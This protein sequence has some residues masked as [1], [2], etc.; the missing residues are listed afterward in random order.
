MVHITPTGWFRGGFKLK[1]SSLDAMSGRQRAFTL[2]EVLLVMAI[3]SILGAIAWPG[4][5]HYIDQ[6]RVAQAKVD[7]RAIEGDL[8]NYYVNNN[9]YPDTLAAAG[10][11]DRRDPWGN[12]YRYLR[13]TPT[14]SKGLLRK[15]RNLVPIN[16]DYDLYSLGKDGTSKPPLTAQPS[17]DDVIRAN[18]GRFVGLASDY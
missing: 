14:T 11:G 12:V 16:S 8:E 2:F 9:A 3:I 10:V 4:Y 1:F 18:N 15:D 6:V 7:I 13:I 5:Q 17:R